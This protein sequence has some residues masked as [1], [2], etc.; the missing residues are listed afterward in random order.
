VGRGLGA[1][2]KLS[3]RYGS[4]L[5][6]LLQALARTSGRVLELGMGAY[7]TPLLHAVCAL[8]QRHLFSLESDRAVYEWGRQYLGDF[9]TL[10]EVRDWDRAPLEQLDWDVALIDHNP[11]TRRAADIRRLAE[12]TQYLVVHDSNG[13]YKEYGYAAIWPLFR[14][15]L[16]FTALTPATTVLSNFQPLDAFWGQTWSRSITF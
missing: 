3:P 11:P 14:Y 13:R 10:I 5:P 1:G 2:V 9:H 12:R 16:D 8:E 7:S 15:K 6:V 4:H